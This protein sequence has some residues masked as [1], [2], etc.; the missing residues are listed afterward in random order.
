MSS[1]CK[2]WPEKSNASDLHPLF[3]ADILTKPCGF[4]RFVPKHC[5]H[6]MRLPSYM[7]SLSFLFFSSCISFFCHPY[8]IFFFS[9][10]N[11]SLAL[12]FSYFVS[13]PLSFKPF[14]H[15]SR[16]APFSIVM[17]VCPSV[18]RHL[19]ARLPRD[20]FSWNSSEYFH[21]NLSRI[22]VKF[23]WVIS[24][25]SVTDFREIL[26]SSFTKICR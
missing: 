8:I 18:W 3:C 17:S 19:K 6:R 1:R 16:K 7:S 11:V 23:Y 10:S 5:H 24:R 20:G 14:S 26:V 25:K 9:L 12:L 4:L 13:L 21:D 22:F 2:F 15:Y